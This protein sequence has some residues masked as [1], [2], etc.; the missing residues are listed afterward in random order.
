MLVCERREPKRP[1]SLD[2]VEMRFLF[3]M[4]G[5]LGVVLVSCAST[6]ESPIEEVSIRVAGFMESEGIT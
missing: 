4:L 2:A 1:A 3:S 5:T 6:S